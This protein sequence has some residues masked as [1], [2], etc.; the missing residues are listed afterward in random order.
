MQTNDIQKLQQLLARIITLAERSDTE[1]RGNINAAIEVM[2]HSLLLLQ[3]DRRTE[4]RRETAT[5]DAR[6]V[7][8]R[9]RDDR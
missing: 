1:K 8:A 6:R 9:R 3:Q 5:P 7:Y 4:F 2:R